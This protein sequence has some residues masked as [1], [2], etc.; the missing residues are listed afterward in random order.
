MQLFTT[1]GISKLRVVGIN[2][3][4][5]SADVEGKFILT[6]KGPSGNLFRVDLGSAHGMKGCPMNLLSLSLLVDK[7]AV[8]HF[9]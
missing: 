2:G 7:G 8:I 1:L 5:K 6:L 4:P 9:E 3:V